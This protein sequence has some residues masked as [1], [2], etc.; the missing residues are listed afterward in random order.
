MRWT[1][2]HKFRP[3]APRE[4]V[5]LLSKAIL[6]VGTV[7]SMPIIKR[8]C[9]P[10][11]S[12][13]DLDVWSAVR[14]QGD[15]AW[16][17]LQRTIERSYAASTNC[18]HAIRLIANHNLQCQSVKRSN[19]TASKVRYRRPVLQAGGIA[20]MTLVAQGPQNACPAAR[21]PFQP[22]NSDTSTNPRSILVMKLPTNT[23]ECA[24]CIIAE[25]LACHTCLRQ[26]PTLMPSPTVN[27]LFEKLVH[28]CSQTLD[29]AK[30][31]LV[32]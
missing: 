30:V 25:I 7:S 17:T 18:Q 19:S 26:L 28:I 1:G 2:P 29:E 22:F 8:P 27:S 12:A 15:D 31:L 11:R 24:E 14:E 6:R 23:R 21:H 16:Q 3:R 4:G 13:L 32:G 9:F 20:H 5:S 10:T